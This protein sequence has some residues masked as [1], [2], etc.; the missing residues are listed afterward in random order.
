MGPW[1]RFK[2]GWRHGM[3][4]PLRESNPGITVAVIQVTVFR[5]PAP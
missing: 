4:G 3:A 1:V 5:I 2:A